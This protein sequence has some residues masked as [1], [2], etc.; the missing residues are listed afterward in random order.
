MPHR[1]RCWAR[2]RCLGCACRL[3]SMQA[4]TRPSRLR[5]DFRRGC[6]VLGGCA[7]ALMGHVAKASAQ[8]TEP[9]RKVTTV[10]LA[11][12]AEPSCPAAPETERLVEEMLGRRLFQ[13][14][15]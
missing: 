7:A 13:G 10:C 2:C 1:H 9:T 11:W 14:Q 5:S 4:A 12:E 8:E 6:I 3:R 15:S